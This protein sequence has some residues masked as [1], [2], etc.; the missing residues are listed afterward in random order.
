MGAQRLQN[1][2]PSLAACH[3]G[4]RNLLPGDQPRVSPKNGFRSN[5]LGH[6]FQGSSTKTLADLGRTDALRIR[7]PKSRLDPVPEDA[8]VQCTTPLAATGSETVPA[9]SEG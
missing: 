3:Y 2:T 6:L 5:D 1:S 4:I 7:E 9:A 8:V